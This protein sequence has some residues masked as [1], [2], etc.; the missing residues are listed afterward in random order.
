M[1]LIFTS[2]TY[3]FSPD[4]SIIVFVGKNICTRIVHATGAG[5]P[6]GQSIVYVTWQIYL[7]SL[8]YSVSP[9]PKINAYL[10]NVL[11]ESQQ[12]TQKIDVCIYISGSSNRAMFLPRSNKEF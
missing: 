4:L 8:A 2:H 10:S 3:C 1:W 9:T 11:Y 12:A 6:F 7:V 5:A